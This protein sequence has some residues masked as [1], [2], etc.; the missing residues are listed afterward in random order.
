MENIS[1]NKHNYKVV[2]YLII[3]LYC[4]FE[5]VSGYKYIYSYLPEDRVIN[6]YDLELV[7]YKALNSLDIIN[8]ILTAMN[9]IYCIIAIVYLL[10]DMIDKYN[11]KLIKD[12]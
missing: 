9:I 12:K 3:I 4:A 6:E 11:I 10:D 5:I 7:Q 1:I 8:L 2:L